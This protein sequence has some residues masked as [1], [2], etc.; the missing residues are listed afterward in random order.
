M[1]LRA[2]NSESAALLRAVA[3]SEETLPVYDY[4][5]L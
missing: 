4:S 2:M 3:D 5:T 1:P